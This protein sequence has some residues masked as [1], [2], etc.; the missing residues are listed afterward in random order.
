MTN[1]KLIAETAWHH[2][3]EIDFIKNLVYDISFK[4]RAD[5]VK[6]HLSLDIEEY[7]VNDHPLYSKMIDWMFSEDQWKE[8]IEIIISCNKELMLLFNDIK[9]IEFGMRFNPSIVEIHSVCL[10]DLNLLTAL[11]QNISSEKQVIL[12]I[13]GSDLYE[14]ENALNLLKFN[15]IVLMFGF[16]NYPTKYQDINF[17]KIRRIMKLFPEYC[18]G[19]ADHTAWDEPNNELITLLGAALGMDYIEKHVTNAYGKKR[20]DFSSAIDINMLNKLKNKIDIL[21]ACSGN[22]LLELNKAEAEYSIFGP[23]KKAVLVKEN[24]KAGQILKKEMLCFK[25]TK[26]ISDMSQVEAIKRIGSKLSCDIK[27]GQV[28][29]KSYLNDDIG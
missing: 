10:N 18:F 29:L 28:L 19:Y 13:G 16:Q 27:S 5:V 6:L 23:M 20:I 14:I 3:G 1:I 24:L 11:Q 7:M 8:V 22:G 26:Q 2:Q 12:G 21:S 25:R 15:N 4:S 17:S 9:A